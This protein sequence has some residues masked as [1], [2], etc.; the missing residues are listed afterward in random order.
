MFYTKNVTVP[1]LHSYGHRTQVASV[2]HQE[3]TSMKL[4][5]SCK[6]GI[7]SCIETQTFSV[8][9]L[10]SYEKPMDIHIHDC[11]EIYYSISGGKQF[12]IDNRFYTFNPGDIFFINQYESHYLS[13]ID[14]VKHERIIVS[15]YPDHLKQCCSGKTD[16]NYCFTCRNTNFG[17]KISLS[18]EEQKRF[19]YFIHKLSENNEYGQD[20]LDHAVFL[21]LMT[22]LNG[23][24]LRNCSHDLPRHEPVGSRHEQM[25]AI[26]SYINQHISDDLYIERLAK[27]FY[28]STSY[29][30]RIF[31]SETGTTINKY[32]TAK[33]ITLAKSYLS[34][35]Y[36]VTDA[37][38][39]CGFGDYSNFLKSFTKAVGISPKK[40][41]QFSA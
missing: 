37:C 23:I 16:L 38:I 4:Y 30:C 39:R 29:L 31:K 12:L 24:F 13:Q 3:E 10:Y 9:H 20:I 15:I 5:S 17:H 14:N 25:D 26:L 40:Y 19:L 21:Q 8:A 33:R 35:G 36:S 7:R 11:Y 2:D 6:E 27:H 1:Y 41:A 28:I 18:L 34:E 32:I 22:F